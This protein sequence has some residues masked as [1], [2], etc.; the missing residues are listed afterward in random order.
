MYCLN[1]TFVILASSIVTQLDSLLFKF[2]SVAASQDFPVISAHR[3]LGS[4][5][6]FKLHSCLYGCHAGVGSDRFSFI[7]PYAPRFSRSGLWGV[8]VGGW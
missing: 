6:L 3:S 8:N 2:L 5:F 1:T 7:R 4:R